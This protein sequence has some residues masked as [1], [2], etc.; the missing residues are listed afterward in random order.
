MPKITLKAARV[1]A[2]LTQEQAAKELGISRST[3]RNWE[4]GKSFPKQPDISAMCELYKIPFDVL[5][6]G[7]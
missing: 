1:N 4:I 5:F 7:Q 6:F 2:G 3:L